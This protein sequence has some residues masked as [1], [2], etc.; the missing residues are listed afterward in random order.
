MAEIS[1]I[2]PPAAVTAVSAEVKNANPIIIISIVV[3]RQY[4]T[5]YARFCYNTRV[6]PLYSPQ[7]LL[8]VYRTAG[9]STAPL[10][11]YI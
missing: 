5:I 3:F 11:A 6:Y 10:I 8:S 2:P 9:A 1:S 4:L 7:P